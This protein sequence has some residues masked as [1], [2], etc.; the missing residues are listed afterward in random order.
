[1][2]RRVTLKPSGEHGSKQPFPEHVPTL[3]CVSLRR[4]GA[5]QDARRVVGCAALP[6]AGRAG[7]A[8][9]RCPRVPG[10]SRRECRPASYHPRPGEAH[11][12]HARCQ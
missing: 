2:T 11:T 4:S 10:P 3:R 8:P 6:L 9:P 5:T 1:M 12:I 7:C